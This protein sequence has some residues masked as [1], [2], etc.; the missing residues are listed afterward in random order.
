MIRS[1]FFLEG[2]SHKTQARRR[3]EKKRRK[4]YK[5]ARKDSVHPPI[6]Q[7]CPVSRRDARFEFDSPFVESVRIAKSIPFS[8]SAS[9]FIKNVVV[10]DVFYYT[11]QAKY[12]LLILINP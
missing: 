3:N 11:K 10:V 12:L 1:I 5:S 4:Q 8:F 2:K 9:F 7:G 6:T